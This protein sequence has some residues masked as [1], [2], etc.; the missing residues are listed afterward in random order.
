VRPIII[1][2]LIIIGLAMA[3]MLFHDVSKAIGKALGP[4]DRKKK[5]AKSEEPPPKGGRLVRDPETGSFVDEKTAIRAE[6][7]GK[8]YFFESEKSRDAFVRK[9]A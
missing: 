1:L 6:V 3:R 4:N 9:Q 2:V 5:R 7:D 8:A